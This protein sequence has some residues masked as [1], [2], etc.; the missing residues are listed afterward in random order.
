MIRHVTLAVLTFCL[1]LAGAR[2]A[3]AG[4][5]ATPQIVIDAGKVREPMSKYIY[6]QFIEHLRRC[7]YGGIWAEMLQ[8]RKF[9]YPVGEAKSPW[10]VIGPANQVTNA[11]Q[12]PFVGVRSPRMALA[13]DGKSVG[14]AQ[15]DLALRKGKRYVGHVWLAGGDEVG[16]VS[17]SLVWGDGPE[18]RQT[19][20]VG[21]VAAKYAKTPLQFTAVADTDKGRLEITR[22]RFRLLLRGH[23]VAHAG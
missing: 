16:P 5:P 17:V 11:P 14:I 18:G 9:F 22:R 23:G 1:M 21:H 7:I 19:I 6:G 4:P 15:G 12:Q 3:K 13:G 20:T 8:D 2:Q 10:K